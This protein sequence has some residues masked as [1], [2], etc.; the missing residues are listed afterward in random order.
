MQPPPMPRCS[1]LR[2]RN[3]FPGHRRYRASWGLWRN[4]KPH[5]TA[6]TIPWGAGLC[7]V[8]NRIGGFCFPQPSAPF[9]A[10]QPGDSGNLPALL[11]CETS[12]AS[13]I[14]SKGVSVALFDCRICPAEVC[15]VG[16]SHDNACL[17]T[18]TIPLCDRTC[19]NLRSW[20][21][22]PR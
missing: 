16:R 10:C 8:S 3:R 7:D 4:E 6:E 19:A 17:S 22:M 20:R 1:V 2:H 15:H 13:S 12:L 18:V 9:R 14:H 5:G 11:C 21:Q